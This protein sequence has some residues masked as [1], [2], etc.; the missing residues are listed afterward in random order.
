MIERRVEMRRK[1]SV[2]PHF[3]GYGT[4][5]KLTRLHAIDQ[6]TSKMLEHE[7]DRPRNNFIKMTETK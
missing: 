6:K 3:V 4:C 1:V 5:G 7:N 2:K